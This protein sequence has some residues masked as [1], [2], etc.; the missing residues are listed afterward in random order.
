MN[1]EKLA[2]FGGPKSFNDKIKTYNTIGKEELKAAIK[3][4]KSGKLSSFLGEPSDEF[5]GGKYVKKFEKNL[6]RYFGVKYVITVNSWSS[7]LS[8]AIGALDL[9]PGDEVI[10]P[11]MTMCACASA[12]LQWNLIPV[13]AD[14]D[15]NTF[16]ICPKSIEKKITKRTRAIMAVDYFGRPADMKNIL[17]IAKKYN[18]KTISD[19][20]QAIGAKYYGKYAGT[21]ADIGGYSLNYHKT[22][23]TGEGGILVTNDSKLAFRLQMIRNHAEAV[24]DKFKVKNIS[25]LIGRNYRLGEIEAAIG[26]EQLK[27][28]NYLVKEKQIWASQLIKGLKNLKGLSLPTVPK[29]I[30]HSYYAFPMKVDP[31]ILKV[32]K[33]KIL[34]ALKSEGVPWISGDLTLIHKLPVFKKKI[35]FGKNNFPWRL[36]GKYNKIN[37][38]SK[39]TCPNAEN[40]LRNNYINIPISLLTFNKIKINKIVKA[41]KKVW[42]NLDSL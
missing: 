35:A 33:V 1:K 16:N 5:Y 36:D 37:Y 13:F 27:K 12:I 8:C 30:T 40:I 29:Q 42:D 32:S 38:N 17:K 6:S 31:K 9:N 11:T 14:I 26:I 24:V 2:I 25:G 21:L 20:A 15:P 41:F 7:G 10:L 28:L 34:N 22:I 18:L 23:H 3:V 19:T 4:V 39:T